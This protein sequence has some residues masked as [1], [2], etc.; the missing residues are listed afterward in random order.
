MSVS[1]ERG[2][3]PLDRHEQVVHA[4]DIGSGLRAIIAVHSTKLGPALGGTRFYPY[5]SKDDALADVLR[6]SRAMTYKNAAANLNLGGGKAVIIGD[7]RTT[8]SDDLLREYGRFV[9]SLRGAYI[10]TEDVGT[11]V[12]DMEIV[13]TQTK[14]V[15]GFAVEHGGSGDPS[16]ATGWGVFSAIRSLGERLWGTDSLRGRH[17]AIQ[18]VGKVGSYL[19]GHLARVGVRLTI[20]DLS[21]EATQRHVDAYGADVVSVVSVDESTQVECDVYAPC[22]MGGALNARSI[23]LLRC[24]AVVG[25]ANN[26]LE[27]PQDAERLATRGIVYGPDFIVNAGG[28]INISHELEPG[29]YDKQRAMDHAWGIG[30][31]LDRVLEEAEVSGITTEAAAERVAEARLLP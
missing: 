10:T 12:A 8:R 18:G 4:D 28:V 25:S 1:Q 21:G 14:H 13:H 31:T 7:P 2:P 6:L 23:P 29:G 17:V 9:D 20:A 24:A 16:E 3:S 15:T 22:A 19:A 26:Q 27:T 5:A 30:D 11:T